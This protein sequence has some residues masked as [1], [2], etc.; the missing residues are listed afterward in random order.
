[1]MDEKVLNDI[2]RPALNVL[3]SALHPCCTSPKTGYYRDGFCRTSEQDTGSHVICAEVT[4][5]FLAFTRE[6]GN[7][8]TT[9]IPLYDFPGLNPGDRWCLCASRWR[10]ALEAGV[11][12]PVILESCH[13]RALDYVSLQQLKDHAVA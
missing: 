1:M 10:E 5:E 12:P 11:A 6:R 3:G 4:A 8:L 13:E 7:D 9:P 2:A